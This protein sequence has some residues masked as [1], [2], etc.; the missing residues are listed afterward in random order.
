MDGEQ[1]PSATYYY[2]AVEVDS[3]RVPYLLSQQEYLVPIA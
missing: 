3:D 1:Y 2:K